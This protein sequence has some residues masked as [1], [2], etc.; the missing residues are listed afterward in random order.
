MTISIFSFQSEQNYVGKAT[1]RNRSCDAGTA[2]NNI[3]GETTAEPVSKFIKAALLSQSGVVA[4]SGS[5]SNFFLR[6]LKRLV[7]F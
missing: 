3:V 1:L 5:F 7:N 6:D 4:L 2:L